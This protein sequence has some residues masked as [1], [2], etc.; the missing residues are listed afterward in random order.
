MVVREALREDAQVKSMEVPTA[1][2]MPSGR[3]S[4]LA[5]ARRYRDEPD[6]LMLVADDP[7][8]V[9]INGFHA[10]HTV[11]RTAREVFPVAEKANDQPTMDLLT[12]R[13]QLHEKT[14]WMLRSLLEK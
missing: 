7:L 10:D 9:V 3:H 6:R 12:Q 4:V 13:M 8:T 14:A 2:V 5:K 11:V 1:I